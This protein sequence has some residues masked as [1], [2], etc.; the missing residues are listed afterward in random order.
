MVFAPVLAGET[1]FY[2][3]YSLL[4]HPLKRWQVAAI[5]SGSPWWNP[6]LGLG[7]PIFASPGAGTFYPPYILL[8]ALPLTWGF[9]ALLVAHLA[10]ALVGVTRLLQAQRADPWSALLAGVTFALSGA[11]VSSTASVPSLLAW[12]WVPLALDGAA[13]RRLA[14]TA[15]PLGMT[16]LAGAPQVFVVGVLLCL[17][18]APSRRLLLAVTL[19]GALGAVQ[20]IPTALLLP[21]TLGTDLPPDLALRWSF[22]PSRLLGFGLPD[23]WGRLAPEMSFWGAWTNGDEG[24][25]LYPSHYVGAI[26]LLLLPSVLRRRPWLAGALA[27]CLL[28]A[29]GRHTPVYGWL[30]AHVPGFGVFRHP[31]TWIMPA[32]LLLAI[33]AGLGSPQEMAVDESSCSLV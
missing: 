15:L 23:F 6:G 24:N 11:M 18:L 31:E 12:A 27:I 29:M 22:A 14:A 7:V 5:S 26:P 32:T 3:D 25:F 30:L 33:L 8:L 16:V 10:L 19:G 1:F 13:R 28:L 17:V 20:I 21:H 4:D 2:G 9:N